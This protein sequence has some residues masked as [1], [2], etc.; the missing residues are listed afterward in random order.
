MDL[1]KNIGVIVGIIVAIL[2]I[3]KYLRSSAFIRKI[4]KGLSWRR[5]KSLTGA[6]DELF[7]WLKEVYYKLEN[8]QINKLLN[9]LQKIKIKNDQEIYKNEGIKSLLVV[10]K[11][12]QDN[13]CNIVE[14]LEKIYLHKNDLHFDPYCE[15][16]KVE[17]NKLIKAIMLDKINPIKQKWYPDRNDKKLNKDIEKYEPYP[18]YWKK[19]NIRVNNKMLKYADKL[20]KS[21]PNGLNILD[22]GAGTGRLT[23]IL[24]KE[25]DQVCLI[26]PDEER[27][28]KA[29]KRLRA[30]Q[31]TN[32]KILKKNLHEVN[33]RVLKDI[34]IK[35]N[36]DL[37]IC[38]H[39]IQHNSTDFL[40]SF[41]DFFERFLNTD[42]FLFLLFPFS[43]SNIEE[44]VVDGLEFDVIKLKLSKSFKAK[45]AKS[46]GDKISNYDKEFSAVID[47]DISREKDGYFNLIN[48]KEKNILYEL[49]KDKTFLHAYKRIFN[50]GLVCSLDASFSKLFLNRKTPSE[51]QKLLN[52]KFKSL[53]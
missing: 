36:F 13:L 20:R 50:R 30:K 44:F 51:L 40:N 32:L 16:L 27:L 17:F 23:E 53:H 11:H 21:K 46:I 34:G 3:N 12:Y 2:T 25:N 41:F 42:G 39:V 18:N 14:L 38:S 7:N 9:T 29:I 37:I 15:D 31:I 8:N 48:K 28:E 1:L 35:Q 5:K 24:S 49:K 45:S 4:S 26:E 33:D 22:I 19:S 10:Y 52:S 43:K 6:E 47:L